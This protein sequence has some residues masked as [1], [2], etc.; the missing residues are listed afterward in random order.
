MVI[1]L[2]KDNTPYLIKLMIEADDVQSV[3]N[4]SIPNK[5]FIHTKIRQQ[6]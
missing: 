4:G 1:L 3:N 2:M 6:A 5:D